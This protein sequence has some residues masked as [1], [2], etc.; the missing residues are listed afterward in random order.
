MRREM[1]MRSLSL[2]ILTGLGMTMLLGCNKNNVD[3][4]IEGETKSTESEAENR[5]IGV[6]QFADAPIWNEMWTIEEEGKESIAVEVDADI[7]I[8]KTDQMS[9]V[10]VTEPEFDAEFKEQIAKRIFENE[11]VY[12]NDISHLPRQELEEQYAYYEALYKSDPDVHMGNDLKKML[13]TYEAALEQ[14]KDTYTLAEEYTVDEYI[15]KRDGISYKLHFMD[16]GMN[17]EEESSWGYRDI[18]LYPKDIYTVC[19]KS[20]ADFSQLQYGAFSGEGSPVNECQ[21]SEQEAQKLA[22]RMMENLG[23]EYPVLAYSRPLMW[24]DESFSSESQEEWTANGYVFTYEF[25][26]DDVSFVGF[27]IESEYVNNDGSSADDKMSYS[28]DARLTVYVTDAGVIQMSANNPLET[29]S[30]SESVELLPLDVIQGVMKEQMEKQREIFRFMYPS[31][32]GE[33]A[34][35]AMELIYFRMSDK[36]NP[37]HYSYVP[38]WRLSKQS[39][40]EMSDIGMDT[41]SIYNPVMINAIDGSVIDIYDEI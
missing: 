28:L 33:L 25:G 1:F 20:V 4:S 31:R 6:V 37:G 17:G 18:W 5:K 14:A 15:G 32:G 41:K 12:Y 29:S 39:E 22:G 30:M 19:P 24:G 9:V 8:P 10:E 27:G 3:Y 26:V 16:S 2:G 13:E 21:F 23:L 36:D 35:N 7:R 34:F 40:I 38:A 11:E